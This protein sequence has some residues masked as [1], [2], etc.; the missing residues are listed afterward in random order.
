MGMS[1]KVGL[2]GNG[3]L[4]WVTIAIAPITLGLAKFRRWI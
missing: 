4:F 2:F 3:S 1:F